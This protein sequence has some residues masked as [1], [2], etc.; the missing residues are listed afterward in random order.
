MK[1]IDPW[2]TKNRRVCPVCKGKIRLPGMA[3]SDDS[4]SEADNRQPNFNQSTE[5]TNER[6]GLLRSSSRS[7]RARTRPNFGNFFNILNS[8]N[9]SV[10][11]AQQTS[12]GATRN[13]PIDDTLMQPGP[14]NSVSSS[15]PVVS[16]LAAASQEARNKRRSRNPNRNRQTITADIA[17]VIAPSQPSINSEDYEP[18]IDWD[19]SQPTTSQPQGSGSQRRSKQPGRVTVTTTSVT[20]ESESPAQVVTSSSSRDTSADSGSIHEIV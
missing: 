4:E 18:L 5:E 13:Q 8:R 20:I 19:E 7:N 14:S 2:L 17:P 1:C 9:T 16:R 12:Y 6:S 10:V 11:A 3:C 15:A